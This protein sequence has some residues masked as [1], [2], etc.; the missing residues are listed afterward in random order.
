MV[1]HIISRNLLVVAVQ[2]IREIGESSP[3]ADAGYISV[4]PTLRHLSVEIKSSRSPHA[5][6]VHSARG[7]ERSGAKLED[8][9]I[10]LSGGGGHGITAF[11]GVPVCAL[12]VSR[13]DHGG[14]LA[15]LRSCKQS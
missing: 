5:G 4:P 14:S 7:R 1:N 11:L 6:L 15:S 3:G 2:S 10:G 12:V 9:R 8:N 13:P